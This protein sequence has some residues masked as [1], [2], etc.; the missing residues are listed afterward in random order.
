MPEDETFKEEQNLH[1]Q[2]ADEEVQ[3][4]E[5]NPVTENIL[6]PETIEQL[7]LTEQP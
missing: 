4:T 5:Q 2:Q 1:D 3:I 6:L 7:P